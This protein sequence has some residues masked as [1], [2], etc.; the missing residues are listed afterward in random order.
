MTYQSIPKFSATLNDHPVFVPA[1]VWHLP[2]HTLPE[3]AEVLRNI[4]EYAF[5]GR[6]VCRAADEALEPYTEGSLD[7]Y[8]WVGGAV[9]Y[10]DHTKRATDET[11]LEQYFYHRFGLRGPRCTL[12]CDVVHYSHEQIL[13]LRLAWLEHIVTHLEAA[14]NEPLDRHR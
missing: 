12:P 4:D 10:F 11:W 14:A 8:R 3:A 6:G 13:A 9:C 7:V 2:A 5:D 1:M